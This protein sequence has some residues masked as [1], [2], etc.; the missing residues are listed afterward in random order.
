MRYFLC[1][2]SIIFLSLAAPPAYAGE[3]SVEDAYKA[4]P[5]SR[6]EFDAEHAGMSAEEKEYLEH[7]FYITDLAMRARVLT[8]GRIMYNHDIKKSVDTYNREMKSVMEGFALLKAPHSL[9]KTGEIIISAIN[10][11]YVFFNEW[12]EAPSGKQQKYKQTYKE[13]PLVLSAHQKILRAYQMLLNT[14]PDE[15]YHN[16]QAFY[17]YLCALDFL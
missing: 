10:D 11:Q 16:K 2:L 7:L 13:N 1:F 4:I 6:T 14:Y 8:L 17:D 3:F 5:H 12:A 15:N 9:K